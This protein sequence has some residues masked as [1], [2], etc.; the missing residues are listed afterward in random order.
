MHLQRDDDLA[1]MLV[2]VHVLESFADVVEG[3]HLVDRQLQ[4]SRF[5]GRPKVAAGEF[6]DLADLLDRAGAK[7]DADIVDATRRV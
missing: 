1:E 5:H 7:G 4:L 2:G 3:K 6:E